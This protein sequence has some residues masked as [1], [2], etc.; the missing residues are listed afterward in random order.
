MLAEEAASLVA[1]DAL[2]EDAEEL[3]EAEGVILLSLL[4]GGTL[5][6][7]FSEVESEAGGSAS[8]GGV[9][10]RPSAFSGLGAMVITSSP[11]Y[12]SVIVVLISP[13]GVVV[14][15]TFAAKPLAGSID[16]DNTNASNPGK[17]RFFMK[18]FIGCLLFV[19]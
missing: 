18:L 13:L 2:A 8:S 11:E 14:V 15:S 3:T 7:G 16:T 10:G 17:T 6:A 12:A 5:A 9:M 1:S 19:K 4:A